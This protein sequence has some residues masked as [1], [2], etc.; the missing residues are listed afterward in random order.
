[1]S[2]S[3]T[4]EYQGWVRLTDADLARLAQSLP[5][6]QELSGKLT[7]KLELTGSGADLRQISG[8]GS[9]QLSQADLGHLPWFL[10]LISPL[11]LS[12]DRSAFDSGHV[13]FVIKDGALELD[14]IKI[15]GNTISLQGR[16]T[17][18]S[19]GEIDLQFTPLAGR[20]ERLHIPGISD[21]TREA[22]GQMIHITAKG[23]LGSPKFVATPLPGVQRRMGDIWRRVADGE[24]KGR[25]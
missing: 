24:R 25:R 4:P 7:A 17:V 5:G 14:P 6:R 1:M 11:N 20:D 3:D 23:P 22:S 15:T 18:D 8:S 2:L 10:Q 16:G 9:A 19:Q 13:T 21:L 12:R